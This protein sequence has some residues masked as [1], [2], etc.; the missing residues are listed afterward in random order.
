MHSPFAFSHAPTM[1]SRSLMS[2]LLSL[3]KYQ[4][5]IVSTMKASSSTIASRSLPSKWG[6]SVQPIQFQFLSGCLRMCRNATCHSMSVI[7]FSTDPQ[8]LPRLDVVVCGTDECTGRLTKVE[9][10]EDI[11]VECSDKLVTLQHLIHLGKS[12]GA[13]LWHRHLPAMAD[14]CKG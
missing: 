14:A 7:L 8:I 2:P 1:L 3:P 12:N 10:V 4:W 13:H 9:G 11:R 6:F 5:F